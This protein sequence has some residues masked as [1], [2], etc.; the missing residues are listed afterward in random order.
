MRKIYKYST[1]L[2]SQLAFCATPLRLDSYNNCQFSC[3]YCFAR[4]RA[5][6]GRDEKLQF[7][8][9]EALKKRMARV[10]SGVIR[11][12]LD[13]FISRRIPFQMGGMSDPFSPIEAKE[14]RTLQYIRILNEYDYPF[15]IST[16]SDMVGTIEYST[17]LSE[18]NAYVRFS[19]TVVD[20]SSRSRLDKG[21]PSISQISYAA[22]RL[23]SLGVPVSFRFQPIIPG[24]EHN[25]EGLLSIANNSGVKHIS[26]E[27]LKV[28]LEANTKFSS[29]LIDLLGG[30][31]VSVY[32]ALGSRRQ[33]SEYSL[34]LSYRGGY[35]ISMSKQA[36][37]LGMTFGFADNELLLHS[38]GNSC[39][40]ASNLYLR[41]ANFFSANIVSL[42]KKKQLGEKLYFSELACQWL[43][44]QS[45]AS[46][47]NSKSRLK[48]L[49][50]EP[51]K[52]LSYLRKI[53]LGEYGQYSPLFFDGISPTGELDNFGIPIYIR[54]VSSFY[55][56]LASNETR[57]T[58]HHSDITEAILT[59]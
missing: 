54:D 14:K 27:Y 8:N 36:K 7:A 37:T 12:A 57:I 50:D 46:Y 16:K 43:P 24:H 52:W 56:Q 13:E 58:H 38:D 33:G 20:E 45:L 40:S 19:T 31:P 48:G 39:C 55:S 6:F 59:R 4:T 49:Q 2:T 3:G 22:E 44:E 5:G 29:E 25:A 11:S 47:L 41:N 21:C 28:P 51:V 9:P 10:S 23:S 53:W 1:S 32:M 34:P 18:A 30:D 17:A 42:A 26:A 15:I 35:L